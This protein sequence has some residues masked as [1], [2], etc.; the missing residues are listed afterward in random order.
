MITITDKAA[1]ELKNKMA[2]GD[3]VIGVRLSITETGCSGHAYKMEHV[4]EESDSDDRFEHEGAVL[5]VPKKQLLFLIGTEVDYD[6]DK[7]A[8]G[9][10]FKNPNA[11]SACGCGESF[12]LNKEITV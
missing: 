10:V 9:F 6:E 2:L 5:F 4:F 12:S 11:D 3:G 8:A 1:E 7:Y